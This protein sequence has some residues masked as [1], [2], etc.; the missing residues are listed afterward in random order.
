MLNENGILLR[1]PVFPA[2]QIDYR[3]SRFIDPHSGARLSL[4][5]NINVPRVNWTM[6]NKRNGQNL[7][8]A[9]FECK[10]KA[11]SLPEWLHQV[12]ALSGCRK[13]AFSKYLKCYEKLQN[14]S[15]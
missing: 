2:F 11:D 8:A 15:N 10:H 3:R 12:S 1:K 13:E 7:K 14:H 5:R 9:V 6:I 4:D